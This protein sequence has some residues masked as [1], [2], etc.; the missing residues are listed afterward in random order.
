ME[1]MKNNVA[2]EIENNPGAEENKAPDQK[3]FTQQEL[4]DI[5]SKRLAREKNKLEEEKKKAEK[6]AAMSAEE[7]TRHE[8]EEIKKELER[9]KKE[10]AAAKLKE[11]AGEQLKAYGVDTS[12]AKFVVGADE[13][14]TLMN[15]KEFKYAWDAA[16]KMATDKALAGV[17]PS[18]PQVIDNESGISKEAFRK[19][20]II[21]RQ[22]LYQRD[23]DLYNKLSNM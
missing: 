7:K 10:A 11:Q 21:E 8:I 4:E 15:V 22:N 14:E 19:M 6:I 13:E 5:I 23:K 3:F 18:K 2:T 12:L 20:S 1:D 9:S 16:I 17:T